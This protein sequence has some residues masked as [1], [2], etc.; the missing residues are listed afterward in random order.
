MKNYSGTKLL[1]LMLASLLILLSAG[2]AL[3]EFPLVTEPVTFTVFG[4]RDQNQAPWAEMLVLKE[5]EKM[6][7]VKMDWQE[8]PAQGFA[9]QK[10]L[11]FVGN[12]LPDIILRSDLNPTE[13]IRYGSVSQQLIPLEDLLAEYAPNITRLLNE[14]PTIKQAVTAPDGHIYTVPSMNLS[15]TGAMGFKNWIN[16]EWLAKAEKEIPTTLEEFK[17]VLIAFRDGDFNGNGEADEIPL[18][19]R[20]PSSVYSLGGSFGLDHQLR[21]TY[22]IDENGKIHNWL[23]DDEFKAYL[24][25]LN[26]LYSEKLLWQDYYK[27]DRPA[28]RSNLANA[29]FGA[30]YMPYSDVF[31]S[32]ENQFVGF[33]PIAGP[34]GDRLVSDA[35]NGLDQVGAFAI[36][37]TCKNPELALRWVDYF[38]SDE[39]TLFFGYGIEGET[40]YRD[41]TGMPRFNDEILNAP[42]GFM[43]A[44]GKINMVPGGGFPRLINDETDGVVASDLTKEVAALMAPFVPEK[45]YSRPTVSEED[46][47]TVTTIQQD[48]ESYRDSS[49]T[50]FIIGEWGFDKWEEYCKTLE[51]I[52]VFE[53][54]A[55]YQKAL[56]AQ[57][58]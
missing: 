55:I 45:V 9:E 23:C 10:A 40:Y 2:T 4:S 44:L 28:W 39:G 20:E 43:T 21:D 24:M 19:I 8:V 37:N 34:N 31:L 12:E 46:M 50:K 15:K 52:G 41:E 16:K 33:E 7:G 1:A 22:N 51:Q 54:E 30:F 36:T 25:F 3:A 26:E 6:T 49:V 35:N 42:E 57:I 53:I 32:V 17:D 38:Y 5:Y 48:L 56:D 29:L 13:I 58:K 14:N 27:N 47:E 11:L 18:G